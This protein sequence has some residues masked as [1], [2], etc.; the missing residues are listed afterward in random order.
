MDDWYRE[1]GKVADLIEREVPDWYRSRTFAGIIGDIKA[2]SPKKASSLIA[3]KK[4]LG[5]RYAYLYLAKGVDGGKGYQACACEAL[6]S[7]LKDSRRDAIRGRILDVGCAVGVTA[8]VLD[9]EGVAGFDLFPDLL[10][11]A[12][13]VDSR[14]GRNNTYVVADMTR[15]WPFRSVFDT[16]V[17]GLVCHHLREQ[18]DIL[19]FFTSAS[20]VLVT[21]GSLIITLPSGSVSTTRQLEEIAGAIEGFGFRCDGELTGMV[22][23]TDGVR[24]LF[25][26]FV[27]L[28]TKTSD[29]RAAVFIHPRFGFPDVRT[30][31]SREQK[32][33]R[34]RSSEKNPRSVRH[35][36]FRLLSLEELYSS[37]PESVFVFRNVRTIADSEDR[38]R[39]NQGGTCPMP[40]PCRGA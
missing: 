3:R 34:V 13:Q 38:D 8:G 19:A 15:E 10:R 35:T 28:F 27:L 14:I 17:C 37:F 6:R 7:V 36:A 23:S 1:C 40:E 4:G 33:E 12:R 20:R 24:S 18:N 22:V 29:S 9:L 11:A 30:P 25:W 2:L 5:T 21:G 26:M 31:V 32:G 39:S 16:V